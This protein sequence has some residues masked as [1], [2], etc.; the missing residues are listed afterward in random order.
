MSDKQINVLVGANISGLQSS[1]K[2][3]ANVVSSTGKQI[4]DATTQISS[5]TNTATKS[6]QQSYRATF[7]DSQILAQ[8]QGMNSAAFLDA[9]QKAGQY[10]NE[11]D[12]VKAITQAMSSDTPALTA[13][14]GVGQGL[15]GAFAA[16]QGAMA[17]FGTDSKLLQETMLKVQA[18]IALVSG[19]QALGG[20]QDSLVALSAT[21]KTNVIPSL[22]AL[23][24]SLLTIQGAMIATGIGAI[25]V[26]LA[27]VTYQMGQYNDALDKAADA[28]KNF[29]EQ[30]KL[31]NEALSKARG[32][33]LKTEMMRAE[34]MKDGIAKEKALLKVKLDM[35]IQAE[36]D[37]FEASNKTYFDNQRLNERKLLLEQ[38]YQNDLA[39]LKSKPVAVPQ[40]EDEPTDLSKQKEALKAAQELALPVFD[41]ETINLSGLEE[42]AESMIQP[43]VHVRTQ[44]GENLESIIEDMGGW[45][46]I[47][48]SL[49][50]QAGQAIG[51][52]LVT[53]DFQ[54][55]GQQIVKMLGG[56]AMQIGAAMVA[57]GIPMIG[58][59]ATAP[60]GIRMV[61]G[62][63][64]LGIL[65]GAM[66]ATGQTSGGGGGGGGGG[67]NS[68][69]P[70]ISSGYTPAMGSGMQNMNFD[71]VVRGSNLEIVLLN[72]RQQNRRIR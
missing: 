1:L 13:A 69:A 44:I 59:I 58:A 38:K 30:T 52:A 63:A 34:A 4:T 43:F 12:D 46:K 51:A 71:G 15:A 19:L 60:E 7:K 8:Q 6:L 66:Q 14:L 17:L 65:G 72:T 56:I 37:Q 40:S 64:A 10:K 53:G 11:L 24:A 50:S 57:I 36:K 61:A 27:A 33:N 35:A 54:A 41:P 62:G 55:A 18:S 22:I 32:E 3:A 49:M 70:T 20:L 21:I 39:K 2:E 9:A 16:A 47:A 23:R 67:S 25:I 68:Y 29:A 31:M 48:A 26:V 45:A 5:T 28:E 42:V